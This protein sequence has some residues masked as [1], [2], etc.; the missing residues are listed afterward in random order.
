MEMEDRLTRRRAAVNADVVAIGSVVLP[1]D[2]FGA[3][4]RG[5]EGGPFLW[6]RVEP[7]R[8]VRMGN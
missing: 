8:E 4:H 7:G 1:D 2:R 3:V 6:S 5:Y